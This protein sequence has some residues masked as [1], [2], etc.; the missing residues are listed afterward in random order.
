VSMLLRLVK[1]ADAQTLMVFCASLEPMWFALM[2]QRIQELDPIVSLIQIL[3]VLI[4]QNETYCKAFRRINPLLLIGSRLEA[5]H[6][7]PSVYSALF[8]L[9]FAAHVNCDMAWQGEISQEL[10]RVTLG[11]PVTASCQ[12]IRC[13]KAELLLT[14]DLPVQA[15]LTARTC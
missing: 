5:F 15:N 13:E 2:S 10:E 4:G 1:A 12:S 9:M 14:I 8:R 7:S 6:S 3:T 11:V